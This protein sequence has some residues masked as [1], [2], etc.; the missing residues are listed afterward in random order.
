MVLSFLCLDANVV[1]NRLEELDP[2]LNFGPETERIDDAIDKRLEL[3]DGGPV[4]AAGPDAARRMLGFGAGGT[5]NLGEADSFEKLPFL[6]RLWRGLGTSKLA[7]M[8]GLSVAF[9]AEEVLMTDARL[10]RPELITLDGRDFCPL[11]RSSAIASNS[12]QVCKIRSCSAGIR[13][14]SARARARVFIRDNASRVNVRRAASC[15][16]GTSEES[17]R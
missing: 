6:S 2:L 8:R 17:D 9:E 13:G 1:P 11:M 14:S 3:L 12:V 5:R 7:R 15:S 4:P 16:S 10:L